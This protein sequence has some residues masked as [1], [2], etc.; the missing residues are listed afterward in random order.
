VKNAYIINQVHTPKRAGVRDTCHTKDVGSWC[1]SFQIRSVSTSLG[2]VQKGRCFSR[3]QESR[4]RISFGHFL[5]KTN[6]NISIIHMGH[7]IKGQLTRNYRPSA[8]RRVSG[9]QAINES[10][11]NAV[12]RWNKLRQYLKSIARLERNIRTKGVANRGRFRFRN[13]SPPKKKSPSQPYKRGRFRFQN[14]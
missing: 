6:K 14:I 3:T 2:V 7:T 9:L 11:E 13:I 10:R 1:T 8:T 12:K 5:T 4:K